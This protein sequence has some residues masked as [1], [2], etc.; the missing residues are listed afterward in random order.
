M[1]KSKCLLG[2]LARRY[3]RRVVYA[4]GGRYRFVCK[5]GSRLFVVCASTPTNTEHDLKKH[6][7]A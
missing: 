6:E 4:G 1:K 3:N 5:D 2:K 7:D